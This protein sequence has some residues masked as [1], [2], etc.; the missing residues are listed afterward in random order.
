MVCVLG[1]LSDL[2]SSPSKE[3]RNAYFEPGRRE[4]LDERRGAGRPGA[5][6]LRE[7]EEG[8]AGTRAARRTERQAAR[9]N[10]DAAVVGQTGG[11]GENGT[12]AASPEFDR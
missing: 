9:K 8:I 1:L 5:S 12:A 4:R 10:G 6:D 3:G 11:A 2:P 7:G